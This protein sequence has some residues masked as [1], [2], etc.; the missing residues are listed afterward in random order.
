M[1]KNLMNAASLWC[2]LIKDPLSLSS[3]LSTKLSSCKE[4]LI[5]M[6][7]KQTKSEA[8]V[9]YIIILLLELMALGVSALAM[10]I[11]TFMA[12]SIVLHPVL[13]VPALTFGQIFLC[14][15]AFMFCVAS[16]KQVEYYYDG[17]SVEEIRKEVEQKMDEM[18]DEDNDKES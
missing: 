13:G 12:W 8:I 6:K 11:T 1:K 16:V 9:S 3:N 14:A 18:E 4:G 17:F 5:N 7:Y 15:W 2:I 10:T